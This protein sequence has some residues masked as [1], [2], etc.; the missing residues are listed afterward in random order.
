MS[1][2]RLDR[3]TVAAARRLAEA[4]G[5]PVVELAPSHT[6]V[7]VER[8]T[9]R[10]AGISGADPDGIPWVNRLVDTVVEQVGR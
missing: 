6:T 2:L 1:K 8:A 10:L 7:S 4:A 5:R 9:L 3:R